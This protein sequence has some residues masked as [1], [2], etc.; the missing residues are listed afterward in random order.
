MSI[1]QSLRLARAGRMQASRRW[2]LLPGGLAVLLYGSSP[3]AALLPAA[4]LPVALPPFT[5]SA[6]SL[7]FADRRLE[8]V[9]L[10]LDAAGV[11]RFSFE[12]MQ[13]AGAEFLGQGLVVE[14]AL[15]EFDP[16]GP[17]P[18]DRA[19]TVRA[20]LSSSGLAGRLLFRVGADE[21][22][23]ELATADQPLAALGDIPGLPEAVRWSRGG[24][25]DAGLEG[26]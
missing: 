24:R 12:R 11:F 4:P 16:A 22:R 26:L 15:E 13:G 9:R 6:G 23:I 5:F 19:L 17:A 3:L 20:A 1:A 2:N 25:F 18:D 7:E 21:L 10:S 8:D 14:G